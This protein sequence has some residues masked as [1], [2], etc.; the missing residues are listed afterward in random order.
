[1]ALVKCAECQNDVSDKAAA[2][3]KCG[4]PVG[5]PSLPEKPKAKQTVGGVLLGSFMMFIAMSIFFG[6]AVGA[7]I[8]VVMAVLGFLMMI[9]KTAEEKKR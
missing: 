3:P 6:P 8:G 9:A 1:M 7:M 5:K 2:C 4:A